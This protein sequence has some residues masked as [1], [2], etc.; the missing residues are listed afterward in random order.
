M[1]DTPSRIFQGAA[2]VSFAPYVAPVAGAEPTGHTFTDVGAILGGAGIEFDR[3]Y[4]AIRSD[5][6]MNDLDEIKIG[7][8]GSL[9]FQAEESNMEN[10]AM[11]WDQ[12]A[13]NVSG[14]APNKTLNRTPNSFRQL[15]AFKIVGTGAGTGGGS[16]N[17]RTMTAWRCVVI[18]TAKSMFKKE[19]E[20]MLD[21]TV[22]V[23]QDL[24]ITAASTSQDVK[25]VDS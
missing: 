3:D 18:K 16:T 13:G 2:T 1:A 8:V 19:S 9:T 24:G 17:T 21:V 10:L 5:H 6:A 25:T 22:K 11:A 12:P 15:L 20:F 4:H 7:D 23:L 14:T